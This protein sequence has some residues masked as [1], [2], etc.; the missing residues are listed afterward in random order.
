[1]TAGGEQ[2]LRRDGKRNLSS[3]SVQEMEQLR[4]YNFIYTFESGAGEI[5]PDIF[6]LPS[7]ARQNFI[8]V[9]PRCSGAQH[10]EDAFDDGA[11]VVVGPSCARLLRWQQWF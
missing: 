1:M 5:E 2:Y 9:A 4:R 6:E 11:M 7:R 10:P 8:Q 3:L